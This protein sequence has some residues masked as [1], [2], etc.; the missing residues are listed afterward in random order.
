[1]CSLTMPA[2]TIRCIRV[3]GPDAK[4]KVSIMIEFD[5]P[6]HHIQMSTAL[7]NPR[8]ATGMIV[9]FKV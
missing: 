3:V 8:D 2:M 1:M 9:C 7:W 4:P 5:I 6:T